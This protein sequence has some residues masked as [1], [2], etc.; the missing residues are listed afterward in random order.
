MC[1]SLETFLPRFALVKSAGSHDAKE[2]RALCAGI[3]KGE[4][5][6]FDKA[7]VDFAHLNE[8]DTR[9]VFWVSR[10]KD[11]MAYRVA[12][13]NSKPHG[14]IKRDV[15]IRLKVKRSHEE[16]PGLL[17]FVTAKVEI[18][19]KKVVLN[20]ITNNM[21]WSAGS[22]CDLYK[23]RWGVEVF[24]KQLKQNLQL[25]GFLGHNENAVRWQ[26]WTALLT[27]VLL[28]FISYLSRWKGSFARLFTIVRGVLW[29][30]LDLF[31][32]LDT[33][34]GTARGHPRMCAQPYQLYIPGLKV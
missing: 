9:G 8:L 19:G 30:R 3:R 21:E 29:S 12:K 25:A 22:I 33:C 18:N 11:N 14:D 6:V 10:A 16:Y 5:V 28:R 20:F 31:S 7:Y 24:F 17:R 15:F 13:R 32:V 27:Y 26:I 34:R 23:A 2:A 4:I 1:L